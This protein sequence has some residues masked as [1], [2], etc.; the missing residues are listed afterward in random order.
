[1]YALIRL[2]DQK[3]ITESSTILSTAETGVAWLPIRY[4][5]KPQ[6]LTDGDF[7]ERTEGIQS[8]AWVKSWT[9]RPITDGELH[10][11]RKRAIVVESSARY[12][13]DRLAE[14]LADLISATDDSLRT[15]L[16]QAFLDDATE[17]TENKDRVRKGKRPV[18]R[19]RGD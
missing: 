19:K 13:R 6:D 7:A 2:A 3:K 4:E 5:D 16:M 17:V 11:T 15:E 10:E 9:V 14:V 1:M 18:W 12:G 8:G